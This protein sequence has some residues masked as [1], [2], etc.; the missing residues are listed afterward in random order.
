MNIQFTDHAR[1]R[2]SQ[3]GITRELIQQALDYGHVYHKQ[4]YRFYVM[5]RK[6][7]PKMWNPKHQDRLRNIAVVV[8]P[9]GDDT[10]TIITVY[11]SNEA[12][13]HIRR[14]PKTLLGA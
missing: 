2:M 13:K 10:Y 3:R 1:K 7:V 11:R 6:D 12:P 9:V 4:G 8:K 5:R 14:K